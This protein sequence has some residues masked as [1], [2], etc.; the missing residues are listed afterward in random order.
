MQT[1][2]ESHLGGR[3]RP[4]PRILQFGEGNFLRAFIDWKIDRMN[5]KADS[6]WGVVIVRPIAGGNPHTLNEQNGIYTVL[7][8]G[9]ADDGSKV[10]D[11]RTIACVRKEL[12]AHEDWQS[13]LA[14]ARNPEISVMISNTTDAGIAY[15]PTVSYADLP[16]V[17]FPGKVTRLLH[18][19]WKHFGGKAEFGWQLIACEL[20][21]HN[22]D[23]LRRIVLRHAEEWKLEPEFIV[24]VKEHNAFYNTL[25]D[26]ITPGYPRGEV[27][28]LEKELGYRDQFM[29][30][31]EYFHFFVIERKAGQP[32][33]RLPLAKW[34]EGTIVTPD[35]TP[36]KARKVAIL[37][38]AHTALCPLALISGVMTV[39]EAVTTE[40]GAKFLDRLLN[41]E[42]IPLLTLPKKELEDFAAAVLRRF[43]NPYIRHQWYDISLNG[44]VKYQTRN[45]DRLEAY[46]ARFGKP[47]PLM[48][49]SL[50]AWLVFYLGRYPGAD[51]L[52][53]RDAD[54][55]LAKVKAIG[56]LDNG[57]AA[58][59]EAMISGYLAEVMFWG[60][61][62]D[63]PALRAAVV[64]DFATLTDAP[65]S[66]DRLAKLI[67][68]R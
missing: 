9:V 48:S 16:P 19:R 28:T 66:F 26:R 52:P 57:T 41:Q 21:D 49:L 1:I 59:R 67:A 31:T 45:L 46:I 32:E 61:S 34:D 29:V 60:K 39:G 51:K 17:S 56:A 36:Y 37:N 2:N 13:V 62:I 55:I 44:L 42:V 7:S 23:E 38:G 65:L 68:S 11:A 4:T 22:G 40:T 27:E 63:T 53:P 15:V 12:P 18:E 5:E 58:G 30:T 14:L 3:P 8:R 24:W 54:D 64:A 50:A 10:A 33:L 25:V 47:A 43:A 6:D 20:I 35:V